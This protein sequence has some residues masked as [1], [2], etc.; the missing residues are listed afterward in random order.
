MPLRITILVK[1]FGPRPITA[2]S[3]QYLPKTMVPAGPGPMNFQ[4]WMAIFIDK[5]LENTQ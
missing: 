3:T 4:L 1:E 5:Y 2:N